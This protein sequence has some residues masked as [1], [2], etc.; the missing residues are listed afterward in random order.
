MTLC[1]KKQ[2]WQTFEKIG[3]HRPVH[4]IKPCMR[5][6]RWL[7]ITLVF[8]LLAGCG[9]STK[10]NL[11]KT[12][13]RVGSWNWACLRL[14]DKQIQVQRIICCGEDQAVAEASRQMA[15]R[16]AKTNGKD[17]QVN[18]ARRPRLD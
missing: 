17:W 16:A 13:L 5:V 2:F 4:T 11:A 9:A 12:P 14:K 10:E 3:S 7:P 6:T 18:A 15:L 1:L 8:E